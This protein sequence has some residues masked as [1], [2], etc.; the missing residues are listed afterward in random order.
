V[1][2]GLKGPSSAKSYG[3]KGWAWYE[4]AKIQETPRRWSKMPTRKEK[5][6]R[7]LAG[8]MKTQRTK[9]NDVWAVSDKYSPRAKGRQ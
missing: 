2:P 5:P 8:G 9:Q 1:F 4:K 6:P 3:E 7:R